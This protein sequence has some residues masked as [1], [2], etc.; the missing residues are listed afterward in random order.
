ML[1]Q[2]TYPLELCD[3]EAATVLKIN[4]TELYLSNKL[5]DEGKLFLGGDIFYRRGR[6]EEGTYFYLAKANPTLHAYKDIYSHHQTEYRR[7]DFKES[8][9]ITRYLHGKAET[10]QGKIKIDMPKQEDLN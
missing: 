1:A 7:Q 4:P 2:K 8:Q 9:H 10:A 3:D 5:E 6:V